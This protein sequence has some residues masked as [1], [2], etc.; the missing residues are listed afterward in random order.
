MDLGSR[1]M[2]VARIAIAFCLGTGS[3][4]QA[5]GGRRRV[6]G[7]VV[8][9]RAT[10]AKDC[11]TMLRKQSNE[12]KQKKRSRGVHIALASMHHHSAAIRRGRAYL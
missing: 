5:Q 10:F 12:T 9:S 6:V 11:R 4:Q 1:G 8:E 3:A 2:R 7:D